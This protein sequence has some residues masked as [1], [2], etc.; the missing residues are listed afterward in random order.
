MRLD[1]KSETELQQQAQ[2]GDIQA[3]AYWLNLYLLPQQQC[4]RVSPLSSGYLDIQIRCHHVPNGTLLLQLL[5]ARLSRLALPHLRGAKVQISL[6]RPYPR[7]LEER[8]LIFQP[9]TSLPQE[10]SAQ[11][12]SF[13]FRQRFD[14]ALLSS[15]VR[16]IGLDIK[17]QHLWQTLHQIPKRLSAAHRHPIHPGQQRW[18][19]FR[20]PPILAGVAIATFLVG[21]GYEAL[22]YYGTSPL[23]VS[24]R[25]L[26]SIPLPVLSRSEQ[27]LPAIADTVQFNQRSIPVYA[28]PS[29]DDG[30]VVTLFFA[31]S[32]A[33]ENLNTSAIPSDFSLLM[34]DT[35]Q[36]H[37]SG[38]S[39]NRATGVHLSEH[40]IQQM[41]QGTVARLRNTLEWQGV[42]T[43]TSSK[44]STPGRP[45]VLDIKEQRIAY[46]SYDF[47]GED[48]P[49]LDAVK[50][51]LTSDIQA[52]R[53]QVDWIVVN[54]D[55]P[56]SLAAAYPSDWQ[57]D[58]A[59]FAVD[60]GADVVVGYNPALVQGAEY[61]G[62]G[63]I[64]YSIGRLEIPET[65]A[66]ASSLP[67]AF[68]VRL[69]RDRPPQADLI[70]LSNTASTPLHSVNR[71]L[72]QASGLFENP[73]P[74]P[75]NESN[76]NETPASE[77]SKPTLDSDSLL[78]SRSFTE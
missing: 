76:V 60:Q 46:L 35:P 8:F 10:P 39:T 12:K 72:E 1:V 29:T 68:Q 13:S 56:S 7:V 16:K 41:G 50:T 47:V 4:A 32:G 49:T 52:L 30:K 71:Y 58:V 21:S 33:D 25:L 70:P 55:V 36:V 6:T 63:A 78:P 45:L 20:R 59:Q 61:Y 28:V 40:L 62:Q 53:S 77:L 9:A 2:T 3:I 5:H 67:V 54:Y 11:P 51:R 64:A 31:P 23:R 34:V 65:S 18:S 48:E 27:P 57:V 19:K 42:Y 75:L 37:L 26:P 22:T 14:L 66:A 69:R 24:S 73:I 43:T 44:S 38:G 74:E 15:Q 17:A